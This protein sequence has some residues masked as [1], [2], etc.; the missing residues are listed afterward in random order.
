MR[1]SLNLPAD[2]LIHV[3]KSDEAIPWLKDLPL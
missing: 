3:L 2:D 1:M